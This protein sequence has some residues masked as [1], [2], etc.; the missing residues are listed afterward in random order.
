MKLVFS[1]KGF[2]SKY[3]GMPSP[4][5]PDGRILS[6]PIP[7]K[8]ERVTF[9]DMTFGSLSVGN[10]VDE[11]SNGR[12]VATDTAHLDPDLDRDI[13]KRGEN[14]VP[15][16]GQVAQAQG[17]LANQGV[18][19][20]DLFLYFG[21]FKKIEQ[22]EGRWRFVRGAPNVHA[23][24][25]WL[26]V[27]E[28]I[29]VGSDVRGAI[30]RHPG[31]ADHPHCYGDSFQANNTIYIGSDA[32]RFKLVTD[33]HVL[34]APGETRSVWR[35]P[36]GFLP[37]GRSPLTCHGDPKRWILDNDEFVR[38]KTVPIGQEFVLD[39]DEYPDVHDWIDKVMQ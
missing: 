34:T 10:L 24:F 26:R 21:W 14:W 15:G 22:H 2:D 1:R 13:V 18:R 38:L 23:L 7:A 31:L 32:G 39:L 8:K 37:E 17:H 3:G 4:I 35:L 30:E 28:I 11:L 25:G 16:F 27:S 29:H 9:G 20:G 33:H 12:I 6:L 36:R 5:F 19:P